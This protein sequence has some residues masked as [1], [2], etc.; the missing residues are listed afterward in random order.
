MKKVITIFLTAIMALSMMACGSNGDNTNRQSSTMD[1]TAERPTEEPKVEHVVSKGLFLLEPNEKFDLSAEPNLS[2]Q[3]RYLIHVY[4]ITPDNV[5]NVE[6]N[7]FGDSYVVV[8]NGVNTYESILARDTH[9]ANYNDMR[10]A[11]SFLNACG[12]VSLGAGIG[13][14]F[15]GSEPFRAISIFRINKNDIHDNT[16]IEFKIR[17]NDVYNYT[18]TFERE[19]IITIDYF[20]DVFQIEDNPDDYQMASSMYIRASVLSKLLYRT[21]RDFGGFKYKLL[22][23]KDVAVL[24]AMYASYNGAGEFMMV[25]DEGG[26]LLHEMEKAVEGEPL[27]L[28]NAAVARVSPELA[29]MAEEMKILWMAYGL[30]V[31]PENFGADGRFVTQEAYDQMEASMT[32]MEHVANDIIAYFETKKMNK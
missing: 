32:G 12:Y 31:M 30:S 18:Q 3:E 6:M 8:L 27:P 29:A 11:G 13:V 4:D 17:G 10:S 28:D 7:R 20:D 19:D 1:V 24:V 25:V 26:G 15:A 22:N 21:N 23:M 5:K 2:A 9:D 16:K 14:V